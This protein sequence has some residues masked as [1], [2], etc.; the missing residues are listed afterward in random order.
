MEN[1]GS[2]VLGNLCVVE[3]KKRVLNVRT[4]CARLRGNTEKDKQKLSKYPVGEGG[5][6]NGKKVHS[7]ENAHMYI[8]A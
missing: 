5:G 4:C 1:A 6:R 7:N 8:P 2:R 3:G